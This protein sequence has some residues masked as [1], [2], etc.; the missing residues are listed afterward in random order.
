MDMQIVV[1]LTVI[2]VFYCLTPGILINI[3]GN[4]YVIA[5]THA[6]LF[7]VIIILIQ[8]IFTSTKES[9]CPE[10][11]ACVERSSYINT[12]WPWG[13]G[14]GTPDNGL[15]E[16][17][18]CAPRTIASTG[19]SPN[20]TVYRKDGKTTV[21]CPKINNVDLR[22]FPY[23]I[24]DV[25]GTPGQNATPDLSSILK[26]N[27]KDRPCMYRL[28]QFCG[29][30]HAYDKNGN[31]IVG[32]QNNPPQ[33]GSKFDVPTRILENNNLLACLSDPPFQSVNGNTVVGSTSDPLFDSIKT[34]GIGAT[35]YVTN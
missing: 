27:T 30:A 25:P 15:G 14:D 9:L 20:N 1:I 19:Q 3:K 21:R 24:Y 35:Y 5:L 2:V 8:N 11:P 33:C 10:I 7:S 18:G 22:S 13:K 26:M 31:I 12:V 4:K 17:T 28:D 6:A 23:L 29:Y 32:T 16:W 34:G